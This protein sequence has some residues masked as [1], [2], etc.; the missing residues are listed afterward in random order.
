MILQISL[1]PSFQFGKV[2]LAQYQL[3]G[4][5]KAQ[6]VAVKTLRLNSSLSDKEDFLGEAAIMLTLEHPVVLTVS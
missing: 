2:Y 5:P 1:I 6:M 4:S 3:L